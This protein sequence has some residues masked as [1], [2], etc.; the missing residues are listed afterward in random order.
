MPFKNGC[1]VVAKK[2]KAILK[3]KKKMLKEWQETARFVFSVNRHIYTYTLFF[4]LICSFIWSF[5]KIFIF[6]TKESQ[7]IWQNDRTR[8]ACPVEIFK[9]KVSV[10]V[11]SSGLGAI[12]MDISL[13]SCK[14]SLRDL[15]QLLLSGPYVK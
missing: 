2:R 5:L 7:M 14:D 4:H 15:D 6:F 1:L 13:I 9:M 3:K 8:Y 11:P 10:W 12:R